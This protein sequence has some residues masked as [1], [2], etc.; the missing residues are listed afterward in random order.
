MGILRA[1]GEARVGGKRVADAVLNG[2]LRPS[3]ADDTQA[4]PVDS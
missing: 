2:Q 1:R 4:E 3:A